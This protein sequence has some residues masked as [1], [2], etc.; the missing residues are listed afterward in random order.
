MAVFFIPLVGPILACVIDG[1]FVDMWEAIKRGEC[2]LAW[3]CEGASRTRAHARSS[4]FSFSG[5]GSPSWVHPRA[6]M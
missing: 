3:R 1:A 5:V 4:S 6:F 2:P